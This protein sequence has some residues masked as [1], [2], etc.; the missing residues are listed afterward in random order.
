M[1]CWSHL[2]LSHPDV[3]RCLVDNGAAVNDRGGVHCGGVTP[4]L[5]AA[6]NGF[7]EVVQLLV[8]KGADIQARDSQVGVTCSQAN[9]ATL[10]YV[11]MGV[12]QQI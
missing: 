10:K 12:M 1:V 7:L 11:L 2:P 9:E 4:L 6:T 5:D 3:V 8:K